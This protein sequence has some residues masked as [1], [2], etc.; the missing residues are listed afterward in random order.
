[1]YNNEYNHEW[2]KTFQ[3]VK[4]VSKHHIIYLM[5]TPYIL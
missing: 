5:Y 1:M 3:K 4:T 2:G